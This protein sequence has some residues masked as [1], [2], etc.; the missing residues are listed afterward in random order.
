MAEFCSIVMLTYR[1]GSFNRREIAEKS[2]RSL[3][4]CTTFPYE[5]ILVDNTENNRGLSAGRNYGASLA[6]GDYVAIADDDIL[7]F[8]GWL[9][10]CIEMLKQGDTYLATPVWQQNIGK[11]ELPPVNGWRNNYRTGS[12]CMVMRRSTFNDVGLFPSY[13]E[14]GLKYDSAK[15]GKAY[16]NMI[17][18]KGYTFLITKER[19][20]MDMGLVGH[21]YL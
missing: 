2:I 13:A 14:R 6:T 10:E 9:E 11:W 15:T 16:A 17:T 19:R 18:K 21:S 3:L 7:F 20:A 8:N 1:K 12:N 4:E 5:L